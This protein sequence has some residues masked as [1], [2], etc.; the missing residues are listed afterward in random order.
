M[1]E[2]KH[3]NIKNRTYYSYNHIGIKN[4]DAKLLKIDKNHKKTLVF[5][6]LG[7]LHLKKLV[8]VKKFTASILCIYLLIT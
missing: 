5:T 6:T 2:V 1:G 8:I 7:I 3:I 4:F